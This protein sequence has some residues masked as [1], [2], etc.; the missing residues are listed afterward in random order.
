MF[1]K[2]FTVLKSYNTER[3]AQAFKARRYPNDETVIVE[4]VSNVWMVVAR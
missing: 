2:D 1:F 4:K 3:G